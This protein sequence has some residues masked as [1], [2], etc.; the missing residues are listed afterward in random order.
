MALGRASWHAIRRPKAAAHHGLLMA[1]NVRSFIDACIGS[2][3]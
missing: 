2:K 1:A 3:K